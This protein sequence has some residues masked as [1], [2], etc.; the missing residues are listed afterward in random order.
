MDK[1]GNYIVD[2]F[3]TDYSVNPA[4]NNPYDLVY[5]EDAGNIWPTIIGLKIYDDTGSL[6]KSAIIGARGGGSGIHE[7]SHI[8]KWDRIV[9]CCSDTVFCLSIPDLYLLWKTK[10]DMATCFGIVKYKED[11]IIHGEVEIT[12]L[13]NDGK[14]IWQ[15]SGA[16]IFTS[17]NSEKEDFVITDDY[18]LATDWDNRKYKFDFDGKLIN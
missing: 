3:K 5:L 9:I 1:M 7:T 12:R 10:C 2:V 13:S 14:I 17:L 4:D 18:I 15:Q 11:Y 6:F 16:D 8:L